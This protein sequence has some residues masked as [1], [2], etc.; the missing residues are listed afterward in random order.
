MRGLT[1]PIQQSC[2]YRTLSNAVIASVLYV[3]AMFFLLLD[4]YNLIV[5]VLKRIS[6]DDIDIFYQENKRHISIFYITCS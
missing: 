3:N 5:N 6:E 1:S 4:T 2:T